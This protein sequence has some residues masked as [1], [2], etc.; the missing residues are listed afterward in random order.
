MHWLTKGII[1]L[2][3]CNLF[4][5][6]NTD[7]NQQREWTQYIP[8]ES[9]KVLKIKQWQT[10]LNDFNSNSLKEGFQEETFFKVFK[11]HKTLFNNLTFSGDAYFATQKNNDS[12]QTFTLVSNFKSWNTEADSIS[13]LEVSSI[14]ID[15]RQINQWK[16]AENTYYQTLVDSMVV[17]SNS[18]TPF[19]N[20]LNAKP[21]LD[22]LFQK[23]LQVKTPEALVYTG[24]LNPSNFASS[25][26]FEWKLLPEGVIGNGV[27]LDDPKKQ[28]WLSVFRG[29]TPQPID[30][31]KVIASKAQKASVITLSDIEIVKENLRE[32]KKDSLLEIHPF[33]EGITE[34]IEI[35]SEND[36]VIATKA[37]DITI[38][39]E[40][41]ASNLEEQT[42]FRDVPVYK[43]TDSIAFFKGFEPMLNGIVPNQVFLWE[44]FIVFT[45]NKQ[46]TE[47][48]ISDLKNKNTLVNASAYEDLNTTLAR[49][50]SYVEFTFQESESTLLASLF[51]M[52]PKSFKQGTMVVTQLVYDRNFAH[53]NFVA[54]EV[55][56]KQTLTSGIQEMATITTDA[57]I[58]LGPILF[59]NHR[60]SG[61]DIVVQ[62]VSNVL[63]FISSSGKVLWKKQLDGPIMGGIN[64]VDL[65]R[66]GRKQLSFNTPNTVY[67]LDRNG[68]AV[69][70]FPKKFRDPITQPLAFFDYD[71]N[72]KY[73][74]LVTQGE[75]VF[76]YDKKWKTVKGFTFKKT[77]SAIVQ[78]PQH[79]RI[80]NKDYILIPE[81]NG[82]LNI[83]SRT[84]KERI[85]VDRKF[86]F[87]AI[88]IE[89]E[90]SN[91]VVISEKSKISIDQK[92]KLN[93]QNL[94]VS[95]NYWFLITGST[96][97]TIDD[98]LLRINGKLVELPLGVY[99]N[100]E[101]YNV[102]RKTYI[103]ITNIQEKKV[104]V[105]D[106][107]GAILSNF[108]VYGSSGSALGDNNN[109]KK[110]NLVTQ[111]QPNEI[112]IYQLN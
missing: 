71:N 78:K 65:L 87:G 52:T 60:T 5:G 93:V 68:N 57:D 30:A 13:N 10:T 86:N 33:F 12:T 109:N 1:L 104:Y 16:L 19:Q 82:K 46:S 23:A 6:C 107:S 97:V 102:N 74:F 80:G 39:K 88:P 8:N 42:P 69:A 94:S 103:T 24:K 76:M 15:N 91:F 26:S 92:G 105:M 9:E 38:T 31:A 66:N 49:S 41:L 51:N 59:S 25:T 70:P 35:N 63:Y 56:K 3:T 72:R 44:E 11:E 36:T 110:L 81:E 27:V 4:V 18:K 111:G 98:N 83:L 96:K 53:L 43:L 77:Q 75:A 29:Q 90:G 21:E 112:I 54:K 108:P 22:S 101:I 34:I 58:L 48:Y 79:I 61:K 2:F 89:K 20:N 62:D 50:A 55:G 14:T 32:F 7:S 106:K 99:S 73:R 37:L 64:E 84:G 17:L 28:Q 100:P 40:M 67:A 95:D 45:S 47:N 85:K